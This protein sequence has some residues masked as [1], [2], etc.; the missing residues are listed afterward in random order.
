V[1]ASE[2]ILSKMERYKMVEVDD[3]VC[4]IATAKAILVVCEG[5]EAWIPTGKRGQCDEGH[6]RVHGGAGLHARWMRDSAPP[7][8]W[9]GSVDACR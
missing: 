4:S 2:G 3:C 8:E 9:P 7:D 6:A 5:E 1:C